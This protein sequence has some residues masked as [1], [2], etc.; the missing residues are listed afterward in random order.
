MKHVHCQTTKYYELTRAAHNY[1]LVPAVRSYPR[2]RNRREAEVKRIYRYRGENKSHRTVIVMCDQ[3]TGELLC[4]ARDAI[5]KPLNYSHHRATPGCWIP[6][7]SLMHE[8]DLHV[9]IGK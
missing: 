4:E 1:D 7:E 5:L 6:K 9:T 8:Q 3:T 2:L